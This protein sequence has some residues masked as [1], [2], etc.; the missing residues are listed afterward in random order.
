MTASSRIAAALV[1]A[2]CCAFVPAKA[3]AIGTI[4]IH[5]NSGS[6]STYKDVEIRVFSGSLFLTSD[7]GNGTIVITRAACSYQGQ[8]LV[9]FPTA[10]ALVQDGQS[11]ALNLKSGT[12]YFNSTKDA[13]PLSRSSAKLPANSIMATLTLRDG[14][15]INVSGHIDEVV[16]L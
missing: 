6:S 16:A 2:A 5:Q 1:A 14:T 13:Q 8:I 3:S 10:A 7:D 11:N 15:F 9:C 4:N 12:L